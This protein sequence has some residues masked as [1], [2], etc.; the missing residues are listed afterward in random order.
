MNH[1]FFEESPGVKSMSRLCLFLG[2]IS[3]FLEGLVMLILKDNLDM[4]SAAV[5]I[6]PAAIGA[7][8]YCFRIL[9]DMKEIVHAAAK[10]IEKIGDKK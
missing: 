4:W 3:S 5:V 9:M 2:L 1:G 10:V 6:T 7:L 8:V